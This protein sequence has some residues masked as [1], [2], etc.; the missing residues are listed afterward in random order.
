MHLI[1]GIASFSVYIY[2]FIFSLVSLKTFY[3]NG[4]LEE[5]F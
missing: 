3:V 1:L 5:H 4:S 2:I